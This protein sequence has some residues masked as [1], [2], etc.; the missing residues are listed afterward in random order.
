V[1]N[2]LAGADAFAPSGNSRGC[3]ELPIAIVVATRPGLFSVL[4]VIRKAVAWASGLV[5][6]STR[7][8]A[9]F[10]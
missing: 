7:S 4:R 6:S 1:R 3:L 2:S 5:R 8:A 10:A 9:L